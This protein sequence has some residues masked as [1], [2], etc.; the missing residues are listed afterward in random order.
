MRAKLTKG[1][2]VRGINLGDVKK[3]PIPAPPLN[4]QSRFATI[5]ESVEQQK[6]HL[7]AHLA[8]LDVLF[9]SLESRA[10]NGSL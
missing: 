10:F 2:A 4:L 8:E 9:A 1:M 3:L 7:R 6:T 5:V